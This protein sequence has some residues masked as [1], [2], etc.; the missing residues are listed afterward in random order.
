MYCT[1]FCKINEQKGKYTNRS[2]KD[3][4]ETTHL[5][6]ILHPISTLVTFTAVRIVALIE[7]QQ[8]P[9]FALLL[10]RTLYQ[11]IKAMIIPL[12]NVLRNHATLLE[13]IGVDAGTRKPP[14]SIERHLDKLAKPRRVVIAQCARIA[15]RFQNRVRDKHARLNPAGFGL[16]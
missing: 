5:V 12:A 10:R 7:S 16:R 6:C 13:Q 15:K 11:L 8:L 9:V 3:K 4:K 1:V 14:A 2:N